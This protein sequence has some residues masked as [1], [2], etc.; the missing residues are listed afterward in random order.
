MEQHTKRSW[1]Q[2]EGR[3]ASVAPLEKSQGLQM[4]KTWAGLWKLEFYPRLTEDVIFPLCVR[5]FCLCV[6]TYITS[7]KCLH[8]AEGQKIPGT[9]WLSASM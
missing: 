7:M 6:Q 4:G 2:E 1:D 8:T 3:K 5:L 9:G